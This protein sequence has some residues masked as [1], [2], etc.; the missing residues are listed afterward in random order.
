MN[1]VNGRAIEAIFED[2]VFRP[3]SAVLEDGEPV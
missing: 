2:G 1:M 3:L